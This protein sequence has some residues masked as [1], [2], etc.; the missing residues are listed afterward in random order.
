MLQRCFDADRINALVNDPSIRPH[1][2]GDGESW[3]DL[4]AAVADDQNVFLLGGH[5]GFSFTWS[6]PG[7]YEV[8]TFILPSG[9]GEQALQL[10]LLARGWM[11]EH[12]ADHLWTRVHPE[13]ANVRAFTLKAG[14]HPAGKHTLDLGSGPVTYDLFDWRPEC[15]QLL[16]AA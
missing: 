10:A 8:H 6:A 12:F 9:R 2:G 16:S 15:P 3:I 4:T 7:T 11:A 5:G 14:F 13:A 1:I